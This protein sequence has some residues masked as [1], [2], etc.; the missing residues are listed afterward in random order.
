MT[1]KESWFTEKHEDFLKI[2][3][4]ITEKLFSEKSEYQKVEVFQT[5]GHGRMLVND[6]LVMIAERDEFIYHDMI[7]HVPLFCHPSPKQVLIIGGGD[8]GTLREVLRH[9]TVEKCTMV[10]I[11]KVVID[12]CKEFIPQTA[13]AMDD[14]RSEIII[15]DGVKF[16]ADTTQ[17]FDV[18][19]I[20]STDPIGPATPL[21]GEGFYENVKRVLN[22]HGIV[23]AQGE[24]PFYTPKI[25]ASLL[26][27]QRSF[28]SRTYLYNFT[29]LTYP[30]GLW[31][32][33]FSS[34]ET[35]PLREFDEKRVEQ[36]GLK[37]DY[38]TPQIHQAA[39]QQPAFVRKE[40]GNLLTPLSDEGGS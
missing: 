21:F 28:F 26:K 40:L 11:D 14:P 35:C 10:E 18:I 19:I 30:G 32:F 3:Y 36:S 31:S 24:S 17:R 12:A 27:I 37:F 6:D 9:N 20:D 25:Q 33:T 29:N 16:V 2:G 4:A 7:A 39:F 13:N 34:D 22:P 5:K 8:G 15:D 38:Y 23:V 1:E